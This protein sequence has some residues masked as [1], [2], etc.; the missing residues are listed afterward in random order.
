MD[1]SDGLPSLLHQARLAYGIGL[2]LRLGHFARVEVNYCFPMWTQD[3]DRAVH[4]VQI[5]LGTS[6]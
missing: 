1:E 3:G 6:L 2:A 5:G 4:G